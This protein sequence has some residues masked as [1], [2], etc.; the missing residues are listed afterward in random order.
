MP[1]QQIFTMRTKEICRWKRQIL[2]GTHTQTSHFSVTTVFFQREYLNIP[3]SNRMW[4]QFSIF[5]CKK[6][7]KEGRDALLCLSLL[8]DWLFDRFTYL[9]RHQQQQ[10]FSVST[11]ERFLSAFAFHSVLDSHGAHSSR[12]L[13]HI[14]CA[15]SVS[16]CT[17]TSM[18]IEYQINIEYEKR[19]WI[20]VNIWMT[21]NTAINVYSTIIHTPHSDSGKTFHCQLPMQIGDPCTSTGGD[22]LLPFDMIVDILIRQFLI[23][24]A[25]N[26]SQTF[27]TD[28]NC[29]SAC[30]PIRNAN[31]EQENG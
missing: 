3:R 8:A 22:S 21:A 4:R 24:H 2:D 15:F 10:P 23:L 12:V 27:R 1:W 31:R 6:H 18:I 11:F 9:H 26:V 17:D 5:W 28:D 7:W 29:C 20:R 14:F 16:V 30:A 19:N 25:R 13:F